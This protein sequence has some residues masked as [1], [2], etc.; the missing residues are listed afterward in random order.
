MI[1]DSGKRLFDM[2]IVWKLDRF[3]R[4]RYDSA[5]Y[6]ATLKKNGVKVVSATEVISEGAEGIILESVL[7][8]YAE[9]YPADLSEK[10]VRG[11]TDNAL[12]CKFNGGTLPIGYVIDA[13]QR[14]QIDP[15]TAPFVLE[16]FKR[17][18]GGETI[19]SIMNWL[20]EQGLTNTRGQK[21]TFNSV[22][23]KK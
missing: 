4:N 16:T 6:K 23:H 20:N 19:S 17:Y 15:L 14:F 1:K 2:V 3:A 8:G 21:M 5:R 9:Y 12:K 22:G 18:D 11:M 13:E 7:E 10:V